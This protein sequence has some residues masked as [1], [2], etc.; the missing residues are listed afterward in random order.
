[1]LELVVVEI[2]RPRGPPFSI[3]NAE[4]ISVNL[5]WVAIPVLVERNRRVVVQIS[6]ANQ[7]YRE[8]FLVKKYL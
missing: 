2:V 7:I 8:D 6:L 1:M 4:P 5:Q 3:I